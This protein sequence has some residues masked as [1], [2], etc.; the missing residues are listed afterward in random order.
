MPVSRTIGPSESGGDGQLIGGG[1][2]GAFAFPGA[3][4]GCWARIASPTA[5]RARAAANEM[6]PVFILFLRRSRRGRGDLR[7]RSRGSLSIP[8]N[9]P[10]K[11]QAAE[12]SPT[13]IFPNT[14]GH[15]LNHMQS[16]CGVQPAM[17][18]GA[19]FRLRL[20]DYTD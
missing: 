3:P 17:L 5:E 19:L 12:Q 14:H 20:R 2:V 13:P 11:Y 4:A 1:A 8:R 18:R 16:C 10:E 6:R 7:C 9:G 15:G